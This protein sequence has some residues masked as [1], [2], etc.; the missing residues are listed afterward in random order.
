MTAKQAETPHDAAAATAPAAEREYAATVCNTT[1][2]RESYRR[3]FSPMMW[4]ARTTVRSKISSRPIESE[5]NGSSRSAAVCDGGIGHLTEF[6]DI[7][8]GGV[9]QIL[10]AHNTGVVVETHIHRVRIALIGSMHLE[11]LGLGI[12][13]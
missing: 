4:N 13:V 8:L 12:G 1:G 5:E 11:P 2:G 6:G 9:I 10:S 7:Y 3:A